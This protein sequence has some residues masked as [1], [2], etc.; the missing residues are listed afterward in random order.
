MINKKLS[1]LVL[2]TLLGSS[3]VAASPAFAN[4]SSDELTNYPLTKVIVEAKQDLGVFSKTEGSHG[5]LGEKSI[6]KTP[7][8]QINISSETIETF[9]NPDNPFY[10]TLASIPFVK[11]AS[12]SPIWSG[13]SIRGISMDSSSVTVNGVPGLHETN[14]PLVDVIERMDVSA[15]P[16]MGISGTSAEKTNGTLAITTKKAKDTSNTN[17]TQTLSGRSHHSE[18]IDIGRRFGD[19]KEWG[20]RI[21]IVNEKGELQLKDSRRDAQAVYVNL[22]HKDENSTTN[23]FF[24]RHLADVVG[25]FHRFSLSGVTKIPTPPDSSMT[26]TSKDSRRKWSMNIFTLNHEQKLSDTWSAFVN[27]GGRKRI[28]KYNFPRSGRYTIKDNEGSVY[29]KIEHDSSDTSYYSIQTGLKGTFDIGAVNHNLILAADKRWEKSYGSKRTRSQTPGAIIG[30]LYNGLDFSLIGD[31]G[32]L[33]PRYLGWS[34]RY[35]GITA[36]DEFNYGKLQGM[37]SFHKQNSNHNSYNSDGSVYYENRKYSGDSPSYSLMYNP[38][39]DIGIYASHSI[40]FVDG[41]VIS[42][43]YANAGDILDPTVR[44]QDEIGVKYMNKGLLTTLALFKTEDP[45]YVVIEN[46]DPEGKDSYFA[47]GLNK[48]KG[49]EL[50]TNGTISGKLSGILGVT[51]LETEKQKTSRGTHD[52]EKVDG[53]SKWGYAATFNYAPTDKTNFI[54]RYRYDSKTKIKYQT[55]EMPGYYSFDMGV[56]HKTE[57]KG[58]PTKLSLMCYN[59]TDHDYW[60]TRSGSSNI[61]LSMPRT[62][63]FSAKFDI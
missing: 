1:A 60:A 31:V 25:G 46:P 59:V 54:A 41:K 33:P 38:T 37:A 9:S 27:A 26:Y 2:S 14:M 5:L 23:L 17:Y 19:D 52:G 24:G 7:T 40:S 11:G 18:R 36:I 6:V 62:F 4:T 15:G 51:Y 63:M 61:D 48:Y 45:Q 49:V 44:K 13:F 34:T 58:I 16:A 39:N 42:S 12:L 30:D 35:W 56:N 29:A 22:D 21:F 32:P 20:A 43:S 47:D 10:G 53:A 3:F 8:T 50:T 55:V 57:I 28:N